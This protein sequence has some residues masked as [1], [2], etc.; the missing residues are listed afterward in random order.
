MRIKFVYLL[1]LFSCSN[2]SQE[3]AKS[4]TINQKS[5]ID[6]DK[7]VDS[8]KVFI[9][10]NKADKFYLEYNDE[11]DNISELTEE[12]TI[13]HSP[14]LIHDTNFKS[15]VWYYL[16]NLQRVVFSKEGK[17]DFCIAKSGDDHYDKLINLYMYYRKKKGGDISSPLDR[18]YLRNIN[19]DFI[20]REKLITSDLED[21]YTFLQEY[22]LKNN[23]NESE[24]RVWR[25]II[26]YE[27]YANSFGGVV[28]QPQK[29]S[30][31]YLNQLALLKSEFSNDEA[32]FIPAY[33]F[34][35]RYCLKIL[36]YNQYGNSR[37]P[38]IQEQYDMVLKNFTNKTKDIL[39]T[40]VL[41]DYKKD[42]SIFKSSDFKNIL[43]KYKNDCN[44]ESYKR[45]LLGGNL[46][47]S[48]RKDKSVMLDTSQKEFIFKDKIELGKINYIDFWASWCMPC[49]Q[50][51]PDSRKLKAE[52]KDKAIH[53]IYISIDED[54]S[55]WK[56]ASEKIG[57]L[58]SESFLL[59]NGNESIIAKQF[60]LQSI[61]RYLI[62]DKDGK[63][64][65]SDAPRPSD[66]KIRKVFDELLKNK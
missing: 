59:P 13:L 43:E 41:L 11:L 49:R 21:K 14:V 30:K 23:F 7:I 28:G 37:I 31:E 50:E 64:I 36:L 22:A 44:T 3:K 20:K 24:I 58:S 8:V 46:N 32:L 10:T 33:R 27:V 48:M 61:P 65:D 57:L 35:A 40:R 55:A 52:Y 56:F 18:M 15:Q 4:Q 54:F 39:L 51:M 1:L 66:P 26:K 42:K 17:S 2:H 5:I 16:D 53:F 38:F 29:W 19:F 9:H 6:N 45:Y 12:N 47:Q 63:L 60:K 34:A 25:D 62:M